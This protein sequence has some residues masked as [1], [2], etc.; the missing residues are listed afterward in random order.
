MAKHPIEIFMPP[1]LLKA[2]VGGNGGLDPGA[3]KRA[4]EAIEELREDFAGWIVEDVNR[5][6][7][8]KKAY[9]KRIDSDTRDNLYRAAHDLRGQGTTFDFPLVARVASS[10]CKLT[11]DS[12]GWL[13][14]P[15]QLI[16][17]HV[18]AIRII[19]RD[20]IKDPSNETAAVLAGELERQ[21]DTYLE[22]TLGTQRA[23]QP[24]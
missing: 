1:N 4:E 14:L 3:V 22:K 16:D 20:G 13:R 7:E 8:T 15:L 19:V 2:K 5:L 24:A 23:P 9:E 10:L 18:D 17:A 6:T 11:D 21:V 12:H